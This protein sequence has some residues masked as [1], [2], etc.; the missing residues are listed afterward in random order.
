MV[1]Y[2][3]IDDSFECEA[4]AQGYE[5]VAGMDE[6][7]RGPLAGP[8]LA[9]CL[10]LKRGVAL[11]GVNDSK[12]LSARKR[13]Q[14]VDMIIVNSLAL[15]IGLCGNREVDELGIVP[16]TYRAMAIAVA[17][18]RQKPSIVLVD[19]YP[20]NSAE[21][22]KLG[23]EQRAIIKGD[24]KCLSIAAASIVAKVTRDRVMCEMSKFFPEY[25]FEA[26]KGY[27]TMQHLRVIKEYGACSLHRKSFI[28]KI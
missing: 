13:E 6:V 21:W 24:G 16:A 4:Y 7:G 11:P 27:G 10:I 28:T 22:D 25:G 17:Q 18:M 8:V 20:I 1:K 12:K 15:G 14:L 3:N 2:C 19:G 5:S 23:I 9:C 26:H